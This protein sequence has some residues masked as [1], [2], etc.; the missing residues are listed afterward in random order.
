MR[1]TP[2]LATSPRPLSLRA[3]AL[4]LFVGATFVVGLGCG[5]TVTNQEQGKP[6]DA[7][8]ECKSGMCAVYGGVC[9]KACTYDR[10]CTDMGLVCRGRDDRDAAQCSKL[11]GAAVGTTCMDGA[12]C[13][14][15]KCLKRVGK[16]KEAGICSK[17]CES[18]ADCPD[19]MKACESISDSGKLR[20]CLPSGPVANAPTS[21]PAAPPPTGK[22]PAPRAPAPAP[23][24]VP[25]A[26]PKR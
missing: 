9:T 13:D 17:Y 4:G 2:R 3:L 14:H 26:L 10:E 21:S 19:G 1:H 7:D 8:G 23:K 11:W 20:F 15:G 25:K 6:C 18:V 24:P 22:A 16:E 12:D 5:K